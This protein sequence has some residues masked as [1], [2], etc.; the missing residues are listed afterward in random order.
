MSRESQ[1]KARQLADLLLS[2]KGL[3]SA[4]EIA[5]QHRD[6]VG[7]GDLSA[8]PQT[9]AVDVAFNPISDLRGLEALPHLRSLSAFCCL[10]VGLEGLEQCSRLEE[11]QLQQNGIR[12][13]GFSLAG[14]RS[15]RL[16]RLDRNRLSS[17]PSLQ[18]C[19]QLKLLDLS[20]NELSSL[21]GLAGLQSL[22]E[23]RVNNNKLVSL[24]S[25]RSLPHLRS[26]EA[27]RNLLEDLDG[28]QELLS[29]E[30]LQVEGNA[31]R[32]LRAVRGAFRSR[33]VR[34]VSHSSEG[35][36]KGG[37]ADRGLGLDE[38]LLRDNQLVTLESLEAV[39]LERLQ[40]LDL[41]G[42]PVSGRDALLSLLRR[43]ASLVE[44]HTDLLLGGGDDI[45]ADVAEVLSVCPSL[46]YVNGVKVVEVSAEEAAAVGDG[47]VDSSAAVDITRSHRPGADLASDRALQEVLGADQV[48]EME[49]Q[50]RDLLLASRTLVKPLYERYGDAQI[51]RDEDLKNTGEPISS[52]FKA[53]LLDALNPMVGEA[54]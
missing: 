44:L 53:A 35:A 8:F 42:N 26:L 45:A 6:L 32:S 36:G 49:S 18:S 48:R 23:L 19:S 22:E 16:L 5:A 34:S 37:Q 12:D 30:S 31:I 11:L 10:V 39:E 17:L 25:L 33:L 21:E 50:F 15:L 24:R 9:R 51:V 20:F 29:L 27:A 28:V 1:A 46:V 7:L 43:C 40:V 13:L 4:H 41:R 2:G 54:E 3:R 47:E 38:L 14:L 52:V